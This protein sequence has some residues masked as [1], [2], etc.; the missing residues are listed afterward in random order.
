[1]AE[2]IIKDPQKMYLIELLTSLGQAGSD[3]VLVGAHS[4]R[5]ALPNGRPTRDFDFV[6]D[7]VSLRNLEASLADILEQL[8][9]SP[10]RK[11]CSRMHRLRDSAARIIHEDNP[12]IS[13]RWPRSHRFTA[14]RSSAR[15]RDDEAVCDGR[16]ISQS[17]RSGRSGA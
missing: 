12:W 1:M 17:A 11:S 2:E 6:L 10:V 8:G 13:S 16:Q 3:F 7:V 15:T 5:F 4:M 9:Y 14:D